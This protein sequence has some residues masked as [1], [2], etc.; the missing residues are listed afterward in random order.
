MWEAE[1]TLGLLSTDIRTRSLENFPR[2]LPGIE[3]GTVLWHS[4]ST[5]CAKNNRSVFRPLFSL[6]IWIP[7]EWAGGLF[8]LKFDAI[9]IFV[10][11]VSFISLPHDLVSYVLLVIASKEQSVKPIT[12]VW[13]TSVVK[14]VWPF[15]FTP[16]MR[17][18]AVLLRHKAD[19][20]Y[21][22]KVYEMIYALLCTSL[23]W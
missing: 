16:S 18:R 20:A 6:L 2:T 3:P 22:Y 4:A 10:T 1:W 7:S 5:N 19:Y 21:T 17:R 12:H 14:S 13:H 9:N 11:L 8:L 23:Q 15:T